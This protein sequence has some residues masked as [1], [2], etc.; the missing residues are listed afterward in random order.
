MLLDKEALFSEDQAITASAASDNY[1]DLGSATNRELSFG[2]HVPIL[3][4]PTIAFANCTTLTISVQT[5]D[6]TSF[7]SPTTLASTGAIPVASLKPGYRK[8]LQFMPPGNQRYVRL[9]YTIGG[10]NAN[11]GKITAGITDHIQ[12]GHHNI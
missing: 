6:N 1:I 3:I 9:Y 7:N 8:T 10:S 12:Q 2:T 4:Q 11:A 5:D